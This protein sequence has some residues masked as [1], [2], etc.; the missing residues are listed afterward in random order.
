M[1]NRFRPSELCTSCGACSFL[2]DG[3]VAMCRTDK[4]YVPKCKE[5]LSEQ[6]AERISKVCPSKGYPIVSM[7]KEL[8]ADNSYDYC[9]GYYHSFYAV[10][11]NHQET[12]VH[13]SSGGVMTE[14]PRYI[15]RNNFVQGVVCTTYK[16]EKDVVV[17]VT[18]I[19][20]NPDELFKYQGSKYMPVPALASLNILKDFEGQVA[21]IGT[22][23]QI[24]ALRRLQAVSPML[25]EKVKYTIGNFCGGYRD[26]RE[27]TD[28][29]RLA[30]MHGA[31]L[32]HFQYRGDGQPGYMRIEDEE[33]RTWRYEYPKYGKL[34]GY[35]KKYRCRVCIDATAELA[36]ISCGDAWIP[37]Y[38]NKNWSIVIIRNK[39][40]QPIV[41]RMVEEKH[42]S[43]K[44]ITLENILESQKQNIT[45]KKH[46]FLSRQGLF[47]SLGWPVAE[48]D[49]GWNKDCPY[50]RMFELK[51]MLSEWT[52]FFAYKMGLLETFNKIHKR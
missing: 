16:Y 33:G 38:R 47:K 15:L 7:G 34:T 44:D 27:Q 13:A 2:S 50:K 14:L 28:L 30:G 31:K 35:L 48:Y 41:D 52:K 23:C 29:I 11:S 21:Y 24:A 36:D 3:A 18:N 22:P 10:K 43:R 20:T 4:S 40:L 37:E 45:S 32:T 51:V 12:L 9:I 26:L 6:L 42:L 49:G 46:R 17:P 5:E 19:V 25:R 1:T 8:F 39:E